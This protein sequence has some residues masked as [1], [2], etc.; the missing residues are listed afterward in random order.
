MALHHHDDTERVE[1]RHLYEVPR[2][3]ETAA[4]TLY[5]SLLQ[6]IYLFFGILEVL[7][8]VRFILKLGDANT[9]NG[10]VAA[11]TSA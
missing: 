8:V 9:A 4:S 10:V 1:E 2:H 3:R 5:G 11:L 6:L 7:L